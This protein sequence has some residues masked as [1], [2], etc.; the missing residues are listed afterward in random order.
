TI[1]Q[2]VEDSNGDPVKAL[3]VS[4]LG[5]TCVPVTA[6]RKILGPALLNFDVRG[7]E[8][9]GELRGRLRDERL[10]QING[11]TLGN[12]YALTKLKWIKQHQP[13]VY[14]Q[15]QV[16]LLWSGFV[17]H[18]LG[19][20][21]TVDY[22]L[23]N[24]TLL[25]DLEHHDWSDE[26]LDLAQLDREKLPPTGPS[27]VV[28]GS[29][30]G[31]IA[32]ELGLPAGICIVSGGH[33]QCCNGVGCGV[34]APGQAMY[35]MGTY[36]CLMPVFGRRPEASVM[37]ERGLSIEHH[38]VPEQFVTF[39]YNQGGSLVKWFR[40]TFA[41][42]ERREAQSSGQDLY[43]ALLAE[44]PE[45]LSPIIALPHFAITGPPA[46]VADSCGVLA[47]LRLDTARGDI[48]KGLVESMTFYIREAFETMPGAGIE[49]ADFRT[50]GGGSKSDAW[51]QIS[52]DILGRPF[53]RPKINEAGALGAAILAGVGCGVFPSLQAGVE[54]MV[55]LDRT[56]E[57]DP[58]KRALYD[59]RFAKYQRLWR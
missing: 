59:E 17:S 57:P 11:N 9:L 58:N 3:C 32:E 8:Y 15:T 43:A 29:V 6:D 53:V 40:N 16:F 51:I 25:F 56:F 24:R 44:M 5:E 47:G 27:G 45:E 41:S 22:S 14:R 20:D 55:H 7:E 34:V 1:G 42:A 52:A 19:A 30:A 35:G 28:I 46:F 10:Y 48:L 13:D 31:A 33:D 38:A 18:M 26:L 23:A 50:V 36:L 4:S 39:L 54:T 12:Q 49:V 21:A 2:A 37:L